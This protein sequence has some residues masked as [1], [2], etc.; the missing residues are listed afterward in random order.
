MLTCYEH[1][2]RGQELNVVFSCSSIDY[3]N[4]DIVTRKVGLGLIEKTIFWIKC[5][6]TLIFD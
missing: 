2:I 4:S 3:L 6:R 1:E 5:D